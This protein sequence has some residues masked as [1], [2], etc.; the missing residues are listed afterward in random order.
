MR[1]A[2]PPH[3]RIGFV[4][5]YTDIQN[6]QEMMTYMST[7]MRTMIYNSEYVYDYKN[8]DIVLSDAKIKF[9]YLSAAWGTPDKL[10]KVPSAKKFVKTIAEG[11][12]KV[13]P[14]F[15]PECT[16]SNAGKIFGPC[17]G[18][19]ESAL[20]LRNGVR[21]WYK[22]SYAAELNVHAIC[23]AVMIGE[24]GKYNRT[25]SLARAVYWD[26]VV[27][28]ALL[29][30]AWLPQI[31]IVSENPTVP[32]VG[33]LNTVFAT[34]QSPTGISAD[35][36]AAPIRVRGLYSGHWRDGLR[37]FFEVLFIAATAYMTW[38]EV[39]DYKIT[40]AQAYNSSKKYFSSFW[41]I[42][43]FVSIFLVYVL[44]IIQLLVVLP[45]AEAIY[46][47]GKWPESLKEFVKKT[48]V[49]ASMLQILVYAWV[50][51]FLL[52]GGRGFKYFRAHRG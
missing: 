21:C 22:D 4:R 42:F 44:A 47:S 11:T 13:K 3:P 38:D 20:A 35:I 28:P 24:D 43:D 37:A 52:T 9:A 15:N 1:S 29:P 5:D 14:S 2:A 45:A 17:I 39:I 25:E 23:A 10:D 26:T 49:G 34:P 41:N 16:G 6:P 12:A 51:N 7:F 33:S 18:T 50:I 32:T 8:E 48:W 19:N 30:A 31:A 27:T 46:Q 36:Y 40:K